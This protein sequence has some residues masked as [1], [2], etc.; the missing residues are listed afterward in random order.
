[1]TN[2]KR[3]A[4]E[5]HL[6]ETDIEE[7]EMERKVENQRLK[8][9]KKWKQKFYIHATYRT[10]LKIFFRIGREDC[11]YTLGTLLYHSM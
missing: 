11:A 3:F 10:L 6:S 4:Q 2:W 5:L 9:L 7:I 8:M 1:M